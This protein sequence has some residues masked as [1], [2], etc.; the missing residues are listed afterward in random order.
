MVIAAIAW[1]AR[2]TFAPT[3]WPEA[4]AALLASGVVLLN[5]VLAVAALLSPG[6]WVAIS[7]TVLLAFELS[8]AV[9]LDITP[10][11]WIAVAAATLATAMLWRRRALE[12]MAAV[13]RPDR[14][15]ASAT[16]LALTLAGSPAV[17][18]ALGYAG[19]TTGGWVL[20]AA[21]VILGWAYMRALV[22]ALWAIRLGWPVLAAWAVIGLELWAAAGLGVFAAVVTVL[23]WSKP[24][25]AAANPLAPQRVSPV[26]ILPEMV[27]PDVL[28]AAGFDPK[29]RP[30]KKD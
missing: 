23:A 29:G 14:V 26:P 17:V 8:V 15:P 7:V 11:W 28:G 6:R 9:A 4:A 16:T 3:P 19:V 22:R 30:K 13:S 18:G 24:A 12:A 20:A 10:G 25:L 27:P 1:V 5:A 21:G 2:L